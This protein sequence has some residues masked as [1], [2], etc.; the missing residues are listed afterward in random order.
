MKEIGALIENPPLYDNLTAYENLKVR[1][2]ALGLSDERISEVLTTVQLTNTGHRK[3][4]AHFQQFG[5]NDTKHKS[6]LPPGVANNFHKNVFQI[7][8]LPLVV[9]LCS[10]SMIAGEKKSGMQNIVFLPIRL[11]KIWFGKTAAL[12]IL[13][14][15][16]N[17]FL[18]IA[19]TVAGMAAA[20]R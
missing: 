4:M 7:H 16:T 1:A 10:A 13:L 15:V 19:T 9:S 18:W 6:A 12:A 11:D 3:S 20:G 17:L 8:I 2:L 14:F 5:L